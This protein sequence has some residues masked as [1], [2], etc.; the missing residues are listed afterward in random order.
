MVNEQAT[1]SFASI[2]MKLYDPGVYNFTIIGTVGTEN[3]LQAE[4]HFV[5]EL[6]DP[7][8]ISRLFMVDNPFSTIEYYL[9]ESEI[10]REMDL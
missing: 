2:D 9:A 3:P 8:P 5:L 1:Y 4:T 7:C 6:V 10:I